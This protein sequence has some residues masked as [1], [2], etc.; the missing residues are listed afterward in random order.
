MPARQL[1]PRALVMRLRVILCALIVGQ[2]ALAALL[3]F[4]FGGGSGASS[5]ENATL[6]AGV[7]VAVGVSSTVASLVMSRV[8]PKPQPGSA[9]DAPEP[10]ARRAAAYVAQ[11]L[12]RGA[13]AEGFGFMGIVFFVVTND[14]Y[15]LA[16]PLISIGVILT[17][18]PKEA[19]VDR[20][21]ATSGAGSDTGDRASAIEP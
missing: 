4:S 3:Y 14:W 20:I 13:L 19:D 2:A 5:P 17:L 6:Y 8:G 15:F 7:L 9:I 21:L 18:M 11:N 1:E 16:A 10:I 12:M